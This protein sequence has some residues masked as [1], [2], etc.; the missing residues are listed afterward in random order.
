MRPKLCVMAPVA[1]MAISVL[2]ALGCSDGLFSGGGSGHGSAA[3]APVSAPAQ[4]TGHSAVSIDGLPLK[5]DLQAVE[6]AVLVSD[7]EARA[8]DVELAYSTDDG[9]AWFP[10]T[11]SVAGSWSGLTTTTSGQRH[12][13]KW[14]AAADFGPT[15]QDNT[16]LRVAI[17]APVPSQAVETLRF[18][19]D[20]SAQ[21]STV[22]FSREPYVQRVVAD[23]AVIC[24]HTDV[25]VLGSVE[26]GETPVLGRVA[27]GNVSAEKE[28]EVELTGL[29]AG[30][31]IYYQPMANGLPIGPGKA[32]RSAAAPTATELRFAVFGDSGRASQAQYDVA[33]QV[34][35]TDPEFVLVTGDVVYSRG[36]ASDYPAKFFEPYRNLLPRT[37]FFPVLGNHDILSWFGQ[38]LLDAFVLPTNNPERSERYYSFEWGNARVIGID[39]SVGFVVPGSAQHSWIIDELQRPK[40]TWLFVFLHHALYSAGSHGSNRVLRAMLGPLFEQAGVDIVFCGHDHNYERSVPVADY[41]GSGT[42]YVVTGGGGTTLRDVGTIATTAVSAKVHHFVDVAISGTVADVKAI[43]ADGSSV[44]AFQLTK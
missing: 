12:V 38:P 40:P 19:L 15:R 32:F 24:W 9:H 31:T 34:R 17:R 43:A 7:S 20:A 18:V 42:V 29:P 2:A 5:T 25:S 21:S 1:L 33:E 36:S 39:S 41:G 28:H 23:G 26:F 22:H 37:C 4:T 27:V 3:A 11:E 8:V 30:A 6:L 35:L 14:N 44:D 13:L 16:K 10:A